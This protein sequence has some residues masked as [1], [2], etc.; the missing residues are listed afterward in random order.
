[1]PSPRP[2][3]YPILDIRMLFLA[4]ALALSLAPC[5][6]SLG[7]DLDYLIQNVC[8]DSNSKPTADDPSTCSFSRDLLPGEPLPYIK[9][10]RD[11]QSHQIF[12]LSNSFPLLHSDGTVRVAQTLDFAHHGAGVSKVEFVQFDRNYDGYNANQAS[13]RFVSIVGTAD[14]SGG[15][16]Y[17]VADQPKGVGGCTS[18]DAW[19][20][21]NRQWLANQSQ[22]PRHKRVSS[23]NLFELNI[24]RD[25]LPNIP[26]ASNCPSFMNAAFTSYELK[27]SM[28][29]SSGRILNDVLVE[30]HFAGVN[31]SVARSGERQ[32]FTREFGLTR[33]EAWVKSPG[34]APS[35]FCGAES[36]DPPPNDSPA[37]SSTHDETNLSWTM[38]DCRDWS[39]LS[40]DPDGGY[41]PQR[42]PI[43]PFLIAGGNLLDNGDFGHGIEDVGMWRVGEG[44][45][46]K[47]VQNMSSSNV[48]LNVTNTQLHDTDTN[49]DN[50]PDDNIPIVFQDVS[51]PSKWLSAGHAIAFGGQVWKETSI[52]QEL[53]CVGS[54]ICLQQLAHNKSVVAEISITVDTMLP[55]KLQYQSVD[56]LVVGAETL[57]FGFFL[58]EGCT[59]SFFIDNNWISGTASQ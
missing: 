11:T 39:Y 56:T 9:H 53:T 50:V 34:A 32:F 55:K 8:L 35:Q 37:A 42:L 3:I 47:L 54:R 5:G 16:Q 10:D 18:L 57:R 14:P 38:V 48:A 59:G 15:I 24:M 27:P 52:A 26:N 29:F 31:E 40:L 12:Q 7:L 19:G 4:L 25:S 58:P 13:T 41:R 23:S 21:W 43:A 17:M 45:L 20:M 46:I 28:T 6:G 22:I 51:V 33:W 44:G 1:M 49:N 2:L 30:F 36:P